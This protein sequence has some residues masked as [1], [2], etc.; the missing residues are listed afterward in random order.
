MVMAD[1]VA[2]KAN[3]LALLKALADKASVVAVF[4]LLNSK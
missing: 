4:N 3:R 1:D 2:V